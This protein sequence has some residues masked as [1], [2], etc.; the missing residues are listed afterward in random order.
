MRA[1]ALYHAGFAALVLGDLDDARRDVGASLTLSEEAGDAEEVLERTRGLLSVVSTFGDGPNS[2]EDLEAELSAARD[3]GDPRIA[4]RLVGCG[5]LR[6]FRGEPAAAHRH[7]EELL[8]LAR[9]RGDDGLASTALVG[10][11]ATALAMGQCSD[12]A[13]H[14]G[15]GVALAEATAEVHTETM[16]MIWLAELARMTGDLESAGTMLT[17]CLG[18]ARPMG[19]PYPLAVTRLGLGRVRL[20]E[21]DSEEARRHFD[22]AL[23]VV[24]PA[25]LAHIE[26]AVL[27]GLG[28]VALAAG[29]AAG[30]QILSEQALAVAQ[31]CAE[32]TAAARATYQLA[33]VARAAGDFDR[34]VALHSDA[35]RQCD[36]T[37]ARPA[38]VASLE[39]IAGVQT[40]RGNGDVAAR[41]FGAAEALRLAGGWVRP[42]RPCDPYEADL[43]RLREQLARA[44]L[45]A[46][47]T[48]GAALGCADAVAYATRGRGL[49]SRSTRGPDSLTSTEQGVVALL[50]EG[51]SNVEIGERLFISPR[52]VQSHLRRVFAKLGVSSR[53][54][55]KHALARGR[56][57]G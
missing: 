1:Q 3:R 39:A 15:A 22:E 31:K 32:K 45:E 27:D 40:V 38:V 10:L 54:E 11:G 51:L 9:Q 34:A 21:G 13:H 50:L 33:E 49:R 48:E 55:V 8:A 23:A 44:E 29:D 18:R 26:S 2:I 35:L 28:E 14:L 57:P 41:L 30:A 12:A 36:A 7:F 43:A 16:A 4:E 46:A 56:T 42:W 25:A 19:A 5:H 24:R 37:G 53:R 47:W 20:A 6:M 17:E 52:T